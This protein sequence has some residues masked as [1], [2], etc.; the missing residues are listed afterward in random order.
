[1]LAGE[2]A[3]RQLHPLNHDEVIPNQLI[4]SKFTNDNFAMNCD[5]IIVLVLYVRAS[6]MF[7]WFHGLRR[8]AVYSI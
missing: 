6:S 2:T 5:Y 1:M 8:V 3:A 7:M 4:L